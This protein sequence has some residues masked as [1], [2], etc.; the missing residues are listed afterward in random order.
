M[1]TRPWH[2]VLWPMSRVRRR[3]VCHCP[4]VGTD[5][6]QVP[7]IIHDVMM[8]APRSPDQDSES[9][10]KL[11]AAIEQASY[12][13]WC[14]I[15]K[16]HGLLSRSCT[17]GELIILGYYG[18]PGQNTRGGTRDGNEGSGKVRTAP[19]LTLRTAS[20]SSADAVQFKTLAW[21]VSAAVVQQH[22]Q[23]PNMGTQMC[24]ETRYR[25]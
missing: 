8:S 24:V 22:Q 2:C 25:S 23:Q 21:P 9:Q 12:S 6:R 17:G 11:A 1:I 4:R 16:I 7:V 20:S 19:G 10:K 14:H 18:L 13:V 5:Q 15:C 3:N